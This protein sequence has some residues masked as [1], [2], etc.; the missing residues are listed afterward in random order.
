MAPVYEWLNE[1]TG[2]VIEWD[3]PD[4]P[5]YIG[6]E[7]PWRRLYTFGGISAV[8]GAGGSPSRGAVTSKQLLKEREQRG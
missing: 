5:P 1:S 7:G 8:K 6:T 4:Q 2:E 3:S